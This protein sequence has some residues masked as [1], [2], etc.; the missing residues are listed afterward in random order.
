M[1]KLTQE[2]LLGVLDS[3]VAGGVGQKEWQAYDQIRGIVKGFYLQEKTPDLEEIKA[4]EYERGLRDAI[5]LI[6]EGRKEANILISKKL[7]G[8]G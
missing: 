1:K 8:G 6:K 4:A 2:K 3:W 7:E 5:S